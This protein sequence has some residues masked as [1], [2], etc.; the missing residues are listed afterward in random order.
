M[1]VKNGW[2]KCTFIPS[3]RLGSHQNS[4][5]LMF[6]IILRLH[7]ISFIFWRFDYDLGFTVAIKHLTTSISWMQSLTTFYFIHISM[8]WG[9]YIEVL[10]HFCQSIVLN[11]SYYF[12]NTFLFQIENPDDWLYDKI[13]IAITQWWQDQDC[14]YHLVLEP[15]LR[16][17]TVLRGIH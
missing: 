5:S 9:V 17:Q 15:A 14:I 16:F 11:K 1:C 6:Y 8:P 3:E 4:A 2:R 13:D 12:W 7:I 10:F